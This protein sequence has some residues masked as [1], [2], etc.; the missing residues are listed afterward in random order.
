[1][2]H[3]VMRVCFAGLISIA[4]T[5]VAVAEPALNDGTWIVIERC[6]EN[7]HAQNAQ[8]KA[9]FDRRTELVI[10][11]NHVTGHDRTV[12]AK[13][14]EVTTITYDGRIDGTHVTLTGTGTRTNLKTPWTYAYDGAITTD[15]HVE[16]TGGIYMRQGQAGESTQMRTCSMTFVGPK[17]P[18]HRRRTET[19][20]RRR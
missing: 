9:P 11:K 8:Q 20:S 5:P 6:G 16:L 18:K 17:M 15:G 12:A 2:Q 1:M 10:E 13:G 7:T 3:L 19:P 14:G 4:A